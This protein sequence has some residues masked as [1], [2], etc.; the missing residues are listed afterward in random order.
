MWLRLERE[1]SVQ[2]PD[3]TCALRPPVRL[4]RPVEV[5]LDDRHDL[6]LHLA[7]LVQGEE[8]QAWRQHGRLSPLRFGPVRFGEVPLE[9]ADIAPEELDAEAR[10]RVRMLPT[11][12][13]PAQVDLRDPPR[14]LAT[15]AGG[16]VVHEPVL[17]ELAEMEGAARGA[18]PGQLGRA[19]RRDGAF[20]RQDVEELQP[21]WMRESA[22]RARVAELPRRDGCAGAV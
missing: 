16:D 20:A 12:V 19:R 8:E 13:G 11:V 10:S 21:Q 14:P 17:R 5:A 2:H 1:G 9:E 22:H 18:L 15:G 6:L 3:G 4:G 7:Q